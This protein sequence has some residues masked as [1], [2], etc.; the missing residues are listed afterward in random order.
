MAHAVADPV[1]HVGDRM[2]TDGWQLHAADVDRHSASGQSLDADAF[3]RTVAGPAG[4][5]PREVSHVVQDGLSTKLLVTAV[6]VQLQ[7]GDALD[8]GVHRD[9]VAV[10]A[11][12]ELLL[13]ALVL[14]ELSE[15]GNCWRAVNKFE[16]RAALLRRG[17][18]ED[19]GY[20]KCR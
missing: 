19:E 3:A 4:D 10:L 20:G 7:R 2:T 1:V 11:S 17:V 6:A 5:R 14:D 9:E 8:R 12:R 18:P 13:K 16:R 15:V